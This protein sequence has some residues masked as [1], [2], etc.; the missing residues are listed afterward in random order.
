[1]RPVIE[2]KGPLGDSTSAPL[3]D[4]RG[5]QINHAS[6]GEQQMINERIPLQLYDQTGQELAAKYSNLSGP[7]LRE[8]VI[9][10]TRRKMQAMKAQQT[11]PVPQQPQQ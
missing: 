6:P 5:Q 10:E 3:Y 4:S 2:N 7:A 9:Q 11:T 8:M 1:M